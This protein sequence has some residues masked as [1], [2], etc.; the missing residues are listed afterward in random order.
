MSRDEVE[1]AYFT[2]LRAREELAE[3]HRYQEYLTAEAQRLR[4]SVSEA[5]AL[6]G[7]VHRRQLRGIQHTDPALDEAIDARL[8]VIADEAARLPDRITAAEAFVVECER[9]HAELRARG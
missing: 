4:R 9:D 7:Q 8:S 2:L 6:R 3:L 5:A 1:A